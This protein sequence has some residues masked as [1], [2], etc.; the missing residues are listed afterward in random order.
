MGLARKQRIGERV[1]LQVRFDV[2]NVFNNRQLTT[3][4]GSVT[5]G[6]F[7]QITGSGQARSG[8]VKARVT[9]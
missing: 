5:S 6:T 1:A 8:Q 7:G 3:V 4:N 9:W 2:L